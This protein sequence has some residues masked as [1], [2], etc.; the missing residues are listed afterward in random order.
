MTPDAYRH[1]L[2][3]AVDRSENTLIEYRSGQSKGVATEIVIRPGA[4]AIPYI[5]VIA[6]ISS[7]WF[8]SFFQY[9]A[10]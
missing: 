8:H 5:E 7:P 3:S 2:M 10:G 1:S 9:G 6:A 4:L